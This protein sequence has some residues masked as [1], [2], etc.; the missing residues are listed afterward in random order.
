M[1]VDEAI[2]QSYVDT[3]TPMAPTL[4]LYGWMPPALSL[5]KGQDAA[6]S[7]DHDYLLREGIDL[8]RR[9]TGGLAVLHEH[10]RTYAVIGS[11]AQ[12]PF[13][14]SV[15]ENYRSVARALRSAMILLGA[16]A[17]AFPGSPGAKASREAQEGPACFDLA[18]A[19][20]IA[21]DGHKLIGSAQ[22]RRRR[23]F[24]QHG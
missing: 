14:A 1:A 7:H 22:L 10:E 24:L 19:Y 5:G 4:R 3:A 8:V 16:E 18:S 6:G 12:P 13:C 15:L 21:V 23:A 17:E 2:L 11:L 20:E 9:P